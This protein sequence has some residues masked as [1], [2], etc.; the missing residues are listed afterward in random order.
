MASP[1]INFKIQPWVHANLAEE[2][3]SERLSVSELFR[4]CGLPNARV[5]LCAP[6]RV[7]CWPSLGWAPALAAALSSQERASGSGC[8]SP[9]CSTP[10]LWVGRAPLHT[11]LLC[12]RSLDCAERT[13]SG[14]S[15]GRWLSPASASWMPACLFLSSGSVRLRQRT[16]KLL[17]P[18]APKSLS[19]SPELSLPSPAEVWS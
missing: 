2:D 14:C 9:L 12:P 4:R 6:L 5:A 10:L 16:C 19:Q 8:H 13:H 18:L 11:H 3:S 17:L 15:Q 7:R 1:G